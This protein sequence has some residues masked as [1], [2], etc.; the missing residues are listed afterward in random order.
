MKMVRHQTVRERIGYRSD[1][2]I[3][4]IE[5][6]VVVFLLPEEI[7]GSIGVSPNVVKLMWF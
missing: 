2:I 3:I 5:K 7:V 6:I 1:V 4:L